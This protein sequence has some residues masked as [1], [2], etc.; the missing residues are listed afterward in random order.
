MEDFIRELMREND[1][2]KEMA[3]DVIEA[4][5]YLTKAEMNLED[6]T[7]DEDEFYS[8]DNNID[9]AE[10]IIDTIKTYQNMTKDEEYIVKRLR[11]RLDGIKDDFKDRQYF[12]KEC[13]RDYNL[14]YGVSESDFH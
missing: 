2:R 8:V 1:I 13:G 10:M 12:Y 4:K 9:E 3:E 5:N 7:G 14:Y 6:Y 11:Q